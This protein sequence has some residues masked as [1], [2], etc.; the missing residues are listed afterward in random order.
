V[1]AG[2]VK[3]GI[4]GV[5]VG[6][7]SLPGAGLLIWTSDSGVWL[8]SGMI[9]TLISTGM[10]ALT[11]SRDNRMVSAVLPFINWTSSSY[12]ILL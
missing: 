10:Q 5:V 6:L 7:I 1:N 11:K 3:A 12:I 9:L 4:K 2:G 8:S